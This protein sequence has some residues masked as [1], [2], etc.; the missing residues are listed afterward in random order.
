MSKI[1]V[2]DELTACQIAAGEV[3]ERPASVV[4]ELAENS[5]DAGSTS[6]SVDIRSGGVKYIKIT[7][8]GCGF[9]ADDAVIAFDKHATSKIK[10]GDDLNEIATL[11][12]RGEA[13]ASI[14]AVSDVELLSKTHDANIGVYVRI[15]G[16]DVL[17]TAEKGAPN[18]TSITVRDLFYNTPARYKFLKKDG[19]EASYVADILQKLAIANPNISFKLTSN[20]NEVFR[21]PGNGDLKSV[22]FSIYGK[23]TAAS[24]LPVNYE[25]NNCKISGFTG[26]KDAV[27][28]NRTRQLVF[29]NGRCIR[30]KII[31]SALDEAYKTVTMKNKF[32]FAVLKIEVPLSKVDVNVHPTKSEVRFSDDSLIYKLVYNGVT[33]AV[34]YENS[35][36]SAWISK[37]PQ[38]PTLQTENPSKAPEQNR[39]SI[40][41]GSNQ[42]GRVQTNSSLSDIAR[43]REEIVSIISEK[44]KELSLPKNDELPE[45]WKS[46]KA[47]TSISASEISKTENDF[48]G[49]PEIPQIVN[50]KDTENEIQE[51]TGENQTQ[52]NCDKQELPKEEKEISTEAEQHP[53]ITYSYTDMP[54]F[55]MEADDEQP[56]LYNSTSVYTDS[57]VVG[58]VFDTYIILQYGKEMVLIDQH[59]AHERIKYE[60]IKD[61]VNEGTGAISP[62]FVP[63]TMTLSPAELTAFQ[64]NT[65]FFE[66][67]GFEIDEFGGNT[68]IIRAVPTILSESNIEDV[69]LSALQNKKTKGYTDEEIYTM[70]CKAA[71]KANKRLSAFEIDELLKKLA[72][73]ENSG[74]C[75]HGRPICVSI[76]E[77]ELEKK[78]KRSL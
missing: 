53:S 61:V 26:I 67:L 56:V 65:E 44:D 4:K 18:G 41:I 52:Y 27:Y 77:H 24:L 10:S 21:T 50:E 63:I 13:L 70:A 47:D 69:I 30:S 62:L 14:A 7:D 46:E 51:V 33:N 8:N 37:I 55:V 5:I 75:P 76:T 34:L 45:I 11:G 66:L 22:I 39:A 57:I 71:V 40:S 43:K 64:S 6:I 29:V 60:E 19:T 12:F 78:F 35:G 2:L 59:A 68:I 28:S 32:P 49:Q 23:E 74:T 15:K 48:N 36:S 3:I 38:K 9:E 17:E 31:T 72:K 73:L 16:C 54:Q 25:D 42:L 58:Q 1:V 20:G